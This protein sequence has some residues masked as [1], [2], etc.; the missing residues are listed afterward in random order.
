M[1][2]FKKGDVVQCIDAQSS[3][4]LTYNY[5]YVVKHYLY[6]S[7]KL[8][9]LQIDIEPFFGE[10]IKY[11]GFWESRFIKVNLKDITEEIKFKRIKY[12]H[13]AK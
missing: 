12:K 9:K 4:Y 7:K 13:S 5:Y 6:L 2:K 1:K 11:N 8:Q 3:S 10:V